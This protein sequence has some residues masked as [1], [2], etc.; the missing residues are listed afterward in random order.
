MDLV[1]AGGSTRIAW[2]TKP[3]QSI[4]SGTYFEKGDVLLSRI[5]PSFE[6][7]KQ[8]LAEDLPTPYG[9]ASTELIPIKSITGTSSAR[10]LFYFLLDQQTRT[11]MAAQM[12]GSTGR[13][14]LPQSVVRDWPIE[15]P[16]LPEQRKI[17]AVLSKVQ[18]AVEEESDLVRVTRELKQTALRQLFTRGL[19]GKP[20]KETEVGHIP[21]N[22]AVVPF[23]TLF[24]TQLG[25][26]LSPKAKH[27]EEPLPYLR[28]K[29]VQWGRIDVEDVLT[30]DFDAR[31]RA[32]FELRPGDLLICEGGILGRCALWKAQLKECYYQKA[33]HRV[34]PLSSESSNEFLTYW[35]EH[36]FAFA[37][38]YRLGGASS[39]IAHLPAEQLLALPIPK[40]DPTEQREIA[41]ILRTIDEK[42]SHHEERQRLLRELFRTLLHDLMTA[43]RRVT[44][45][46]LSALGA[47]A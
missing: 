16:P 7:G 38:V 19:R 5:T 35:L 29:N 12:E 23:R 18:E 15:L 43:R 42:I 10:F 44:G 3:R 9:Y 6:N 41:A 4:T 11:A 33:L 31:E 22:W 26:M 24:Q 28:N 27:G 14:R 36:A 46:H 20:Q 30:M 34:R 21:E 39:T 1:P 8:G 45:L 13:Q 40:P 37:N 47:T 17:S 2:V 32:K 25:K